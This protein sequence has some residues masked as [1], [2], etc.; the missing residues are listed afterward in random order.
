[1]FH[2]R[3]ASNVS[4]PQKSLVLFIDIL[5]LTNNMMKKLQLYMN[6]AKKSA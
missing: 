6:I 5:A 3:I 2:E 1:M 4:S